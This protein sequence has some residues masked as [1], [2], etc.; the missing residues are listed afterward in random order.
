MSEK[1]FV[2]DSPLDVAYETGVSGALPW[3]AMSAR[4]ASPSACC[5]ALHDASGTRLHES[6][7]PASGAFVTRACQTRWAPST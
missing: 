7:A 6:R 4:Q 5:S 3:D 1:V 2:Y